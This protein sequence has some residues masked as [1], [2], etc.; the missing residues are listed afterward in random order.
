M[1]ALQTLQEM[2]Y[3]HKREAYKHVPTSAIPKT[4][5]SDKNANSLTKAILAFLK[6]KGNMAWRQSSEG[7]YRPG[8]E[9]TDVLG[10]VRQMKG[11]YLPGQNNGQSDVAAIVGGQFI[12]VEVKMKDKQS[13]AQKDYQ[14]QVEQS[15][16]RYLIA[17]D[18]EIFFQWY[19]TFTKDL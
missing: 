15:G 16:G 13:Q 8:K 18:F 19:N 11:Q 5:Y 12:A 17:R 6:L 4:R 3:E 10:H 9:Y 14:H 7:R 1:T 2:D